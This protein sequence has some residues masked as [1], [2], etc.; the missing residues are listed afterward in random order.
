MQGL[1]WML[2]RQNLS[3]WMNL[4]GLDSM[5]SYFLLALGNKNTFQLHHWLSHAQNLLHM[6]QKS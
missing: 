6:L 5:I 3:P 1:F 4:K 2:W